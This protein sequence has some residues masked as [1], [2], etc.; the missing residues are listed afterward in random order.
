MLYE[1]LRFIWYTFSVNVFM[2]TK[3]LKDKINVVRV[4]KF[5]LAYI[6]DTTYPLH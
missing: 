5:Q 1:G 3:F 4:T 6:C 2:S